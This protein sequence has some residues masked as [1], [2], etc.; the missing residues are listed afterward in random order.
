VTVTSQARDVSAAVLASGDE[1]ALAALRRRM[2]HRVLTHRGRYWTEAPRGFYQPIHWLARQRA[3]EATA[4]RSLAWGFRGRC[5]MTTVDRT[6]MGP[7][8]SIS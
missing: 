3:D 8:R 4:P 2:G 6:G 7:F 5:A 1:E